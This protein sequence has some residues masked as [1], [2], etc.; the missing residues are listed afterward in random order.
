[1]V[2]AA[3]PWLRD[4]S[5]PINLDILIYKLVKA[6]LHATPFKRAA[7][8]VHPPLLTRAHACVCLPFKNFVLYLNPDSESIIH[9]VDS[10]LKFIM[11]GNIIGNELRK[12]GANRLTI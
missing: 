8:K 4:D 9:H 3:H 1:L 2:I 11:E 6:Y 7:L 5:R 12:Y 10:K